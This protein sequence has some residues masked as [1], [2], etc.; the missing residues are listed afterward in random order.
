VL[1]MEYKKAAQNGL[2][3]K[4]II[5]LDNY[6]NKGNEDKTCYLF[7]TRYLSGYYL[8]QRFDWNKDL[9]YDFIE[10]YQK[11]KVITPEAE[12]SKLLKYLVDSTLNVFI[13]KEETTMTEIIH[14]LERA[15][16]LSGDNSFL[17]EIESYKRV[18]K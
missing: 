1:E 14:Y 7:L 3:Y 11:L 15:N 8:L 18:I 12:F 13:Q 2:F 6:I 17:K 9:T 4:N 5:D 10:I 16:E